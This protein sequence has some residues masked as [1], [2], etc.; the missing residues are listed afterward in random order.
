MTN[1]MRAWEVVEEVWKND[2]LGIEVFWRDICTEK[3]YNI[4]LG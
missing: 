4:V 3:G 1:I 2:D